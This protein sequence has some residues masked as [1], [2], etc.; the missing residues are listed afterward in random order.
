MDVAAAVGEFDSIFAAT[1]IHVL[2]LQKWKHPVLLCPVINS[3]P[4]GKG[5]VPVLRRTAGPKIQSPQFV[6]WPTSTQA[7]HTPYPCLSSILFVWRV[8]LMSTTMC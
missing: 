6:N 7:S 2:M 5:T 8:K 1:E 3:K 4:K